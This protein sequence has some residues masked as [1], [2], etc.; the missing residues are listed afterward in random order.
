MAELTE[1]F[2][3]VGTYRTHY[4][5][6]GAGEH[7]LLLHSADPGSGGALEFRHNLGP[8]SEHFHVVAPDII[9][10]G[11]TDPPKELLTSH[12]PYVAHILAFMDAVGLDRTHLFGNSRGG[13]IAISIAG[14]HPERVRRV[15]L[16]GN[17]GGGIPP[18]MIPV[19]LAPFANYKPDR[20]NLRAVLGR[21]YYDLDKSVPPDVFEQYYQA[22]I[23]QYEAYARLGGYPMD[24]PNLNALLE[25][26]TVPVLFFFGKEDKVFPVDQGLRAFK[27]TP[28]SR[29]YG[30]SQC[31][32]HPQT[33]HPQEFNRIALAF[34]QGQ[35]A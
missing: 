21:S 15:I 16:A 26:M 27:S 5:E 33:E 35:L 8:F 12:P 17:A 10:F 9:G 30:L 31:G 32:H 19:A 23:P 7:L 4:W 22:S 28:G 13:L 34:L 6:G 25:T 1:R 18:E 11:K 29:F 2:V 24:V 20:D 3:Q 14:E